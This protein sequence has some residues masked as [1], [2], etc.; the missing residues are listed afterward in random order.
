VAED[1][2]LKR[3]L[4]YVLG[5]ARGG[6]NRARFIHELSVRPQNLNQLAEKLGVDY[7]TVTHHAN[8]LRS[9]SLVV[10]EGE[11]YGAVYFLSPRLQA[12]FEMFREI[13]EALHFRL[14]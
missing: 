6:E 5:G 8:V 3:L 4:W 14:E 11:R 10:V 12:S 7:R 9:N 1:V 13:V 2:E